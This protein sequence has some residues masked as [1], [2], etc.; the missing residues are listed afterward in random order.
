[1]TLVGHGIVTRMSQGITCV[2]RCHRLGH[3]SGYV[4][5]R[6]WLSES[7]TLSSTTTELHITYTTPLES[8]SIHQHNSLIVMPMTQLHQY[9]TTIPPHGHDT[10][11][12]GV[13]RK[14]LHCPL[15][16]TLQLW[17]T[18]SPKKARHKGQHYVLLPTPRPDSYPSLL[19]QMSTNSQHQTWPPECRK[20]APSLPC[21][22]NRLC[23]YERCGCIGTMHLKGGVMSGYACLGIVA[24]SSR[25]R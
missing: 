14:S 21:T 19:H 3:H 6:G 24:E 12:Q 10:N 4:L 22:G 18:M 9:P 25:G 5:T 11:G 1:M 15:H 20:R 13:G 2:F 7:S 17:C 23:R 16:M 8:P